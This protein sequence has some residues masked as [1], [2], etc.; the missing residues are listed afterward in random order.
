M[1]R[2]AGRPAYVSVD[3]PFDVGHVV[4]S[5]ATA[6]PTDMIVDDKRKSRPS[7]ALPVRLLSTTHPL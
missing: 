2:Y 5:A 4:E 7:V 3:A 1:S 6:S